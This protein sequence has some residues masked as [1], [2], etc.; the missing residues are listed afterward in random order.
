MLANCEFNIVWNSISEY[1]L[2]PIVMIFKG[3]QI[4]KNISVDLIEILG[5]IWFFDLRSNNLA[6][7][8]F[9]EVLFLREKTSKR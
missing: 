1:D 7:A 2:W 5:E 4:F 3:E 8:E 6:L 9:L